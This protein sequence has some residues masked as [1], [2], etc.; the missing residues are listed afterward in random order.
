[1]TFEVI[2]EAKL[3]FKS[4]SPAVIL[5][6]RPALD[7][8]TALLRHKKFDSKTKISKIEKD[9]DCVG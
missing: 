6:E 9:E 2:F 5:Q 3:D 8:F 7:A 4:F 1:M